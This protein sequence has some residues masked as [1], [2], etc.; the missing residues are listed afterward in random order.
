MKTAESKTTATAQHLQTKG[1]EQQPFFQQERS[2]SYL[3]GGSSAFFSP[4][5]NPQPFFSKPVIQTKLTIGQPGDKYEQ[6]ADQMADQVVQRLA[7]NNSQSQ[8]PLAAQGQTGL[9]I[10][11]KPIFESNAEPNLQAK[12]ISSP[13]KSIN[14]IQTKCADC[15]QEEKLQKKEQPGEEEQL[16]KKPI[17]ESN[18]E[19]TETPIQPKP[20]N[21]PT[22][23]KQCAA[24]AAKEE[25]PK[26]QRQSDSATTP[27]ATSSLESRLSSSR[28]GGSPLP[29]KTRTQMEGSFGSD[30]S[31]VRVHTDSSAVQMNKELG[32]QAFTHGSDVYFNA[33]KYDAG[34]REG[35]RLLGHELTHVVQQ[36]GEV[37]IQKREYGPAESTANMTPSD[38]TH[39][40]RLN[41]TTVWSYANE[42]NLARGR[43]TEYMQIDQRRDFYLWFYELMA[44]RGHDVRWPLAAYIV[45]NGANELANRDR[46]NYVRSNSLEAI[47]RRGNQVI[48][49]DVFPKLRNL[50][51]QRDTLVGVDA[52]N[53]DMDVLIQEQNLI[54]PLYAD[55]DDSALNAL[56][57]VT[58]QSGLAVSIGSYFFG[59]VSPGSYNSGGS[60]PPFPSTY[61]L[62]NPNDRFRYGMLLAYY[63][64]PAASVSEIISRRLGAID[65]ANGLPIPYVPQI[66]QNGD[67]LNQV[68]SMQSVHVFS[69]YLTDMGIDINLLRR[70]IHGMNSRERYT[71]MTD[72]WYRAMLMHYHRM[73][74][75]QA[76][77]FLT[78]EDIQGCGPIYK[79]V[80]P[81]EGTGY[82]HVEDNILASEINRRDHFAMGAGGTRVKVR[83]ANDN[84][85]RLFVRVPER[86][87]WSDSLHCQDYSPV[88][89]DPIPAP[90]VLNYELFF[91]TGS[92]DIY[93][94]SY[95][96]RNSSSLNTVLDDIRY[97]TNQFTSATFSLS[98]IG[99]ASP[100]YRSA[101]S[102][103]ESIIENEEL[104]W[105]RVEAVRNQIMYFYQ[106]NIPVGATGSIPFRMTLANTLPFANI[107]TH[108]I[109]ATEGFAMTADPTNNEERFRRVGISLSFVF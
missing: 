26:V 39:Y 44:S 88:P 96:M 79:I 70:I 24:C 25:P 17:F 62:T 14:H 45:A 46:F 23:Q 41:K 21:V 53:W 71:I 59:D 74:N 84:A 85:R 38:W 107:S 43:N 69:S 27:N 8:D 56:R 91:E 2:N 81:I 67:M 103:S 78:S 65:Y 16:Q 87:I 105:Q 10:Q 83:A 4:N 108:G 102:L 50:Y 55:M 99:H 13:T 68:D 33:G 98:L 92:S 3:G 15:E 29:K 82:A 63:F 19:P 93:N 106:E 51:L 22:L 18:G 76:E 5:H 1:E 73:P 75:E 100:R 54:Q 36:E 60:V 86:W 57:E 32:A 40:D 12:F 52:L 28:G 64:A 72:P 77:A 80:G 9:K 58:R 66:Y 104:S 61:D 7:E 94:R 42:Y 30:F 48:F 47:M 97:Y 35:Q 20:E 89:P 109:G 101:R 49:D 6:E 95:G 37:K 11:R 34:S 90:F 31:G